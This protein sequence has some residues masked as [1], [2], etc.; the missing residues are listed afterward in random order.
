MSRTR[1]I[2]VAE[3]KRHAPRLLATLDREPGSETHG[4]FDRTHWGW[5]LR[6]FPVTMLQYGLVPL[7]RLYAGAVP[8]SGYEGNE[9]LR[10]WIDG[11]LQHLLA[12][13]RSDG[14]FDSVAPNAPDHGVSVGMA[15][16]IDEVRQ[17]L[18]LPTGGEL[19][20]AIVR[21]AAY[22]LDSEE[23]YAFISN[24]QALVALGFQR[25]AAFDARFEPAAEK[26]IDTIL[27][28]QSPDGPFEEY[29]GPDPG[30]ET[31]GL[32]YLALL[33][34]ETGSAKLLEALRRSV[35]FL[36]HCIHPDG[37]S[38]GAY[39]SRH[40]HVFH[41]GGLAILASEIPEAAAIL[42][43]VSARLET[44]PVVT[45]DIVDA[46]NLPVL[47]HGYVEAAA[48]SDLPAAVPSLP[49]ESLSGH[50]DFEDAGI[51]VVGND[52]YY[53]VLSSKKG[54]VCRVHERGGRLLH[55]DAGWLLQDG[56]RRFTSQR[57]TLGSLVSADEADTLSC[58]A[59]FAAVDLPIP[60]PFRFLLLRVANLTLF[61]WPLLAILLRRWIVGRLI[62]HVEEAPFSL[63]RKFRFGA[64]EVEIFD[65]VVSTSSRSLTSAQLVREFTSIH[66]GSARYFHP[67]ELDPIAASP[68]ESLHAE[69]MSQGE[70]TLR[71]RVGVDTDSMTRASTADDSETEVSR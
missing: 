49:C 34:R 28:R 45:L 42:G 8:G 60:T 16:V 22:G 9:R 12:C 31:L 26:T 58:R 10:G 2:L 64:T 37:S 15:Y 53:A 25:A 39:G 54:G 66:M 52:V 21:A 68:S 50:V 14:G 47:L 32:S 63:E 36:S 17:Q 40:T 57:M 62:T 71:T 67:S 43:F 7:A 23:D 38:G 3:V 51:H 70:I 29:G 4:S 69:L 59:R 41:P 6:D 5:K 46:E 27:A 1:D 30:Y 44:N 35:R 33:W 56:K 18:G 61:R 11:G 24:H 20:D 19:E 65:R 48:V 13:Q 55:Q